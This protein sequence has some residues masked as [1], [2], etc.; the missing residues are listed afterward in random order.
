MRI[1]FLLKLTQDQISISIS[2]SAAPS[3]R[4][5][6][7]LANKELIYKFFFFGKLD[8]LPDGVKDQAISTHRHF[9]D[10]L[11]VLFFIIEVPLDQ[12]SILS[13]TLFQCMLMFA[14][15][16]RWRTTKLLLSWTTSTVYLIWNA[17]EHLL[18]LSKK[19][20]A[21]KKRNSLLLYYFLYYRNIRS[22]S[23][24]LSL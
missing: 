5:V 22:F 7:S 6:H 17:T 3:L 15:M 18:F 10:S 4:V 12:L 19:L 21:F 8:L 23:S 14:L 16:L 20:R 2:C 9:F 11:L 24:H 1:R 13:C